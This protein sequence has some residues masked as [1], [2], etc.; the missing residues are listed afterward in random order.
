MIDFK[1]SI[2][3]SAE[4]VGSGYDLVLDDRNCECEEG[5]LA[6]QQY[7]RADLVPQ[8]QPIETMPANKLVFVL[9][10]SK[11]NTFTTML[12]LDGSTKNMGGAT[13]WMPIPKVPE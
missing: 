11:I 1:K 8:W 13:H 9:I 7:I 4:D 2:W 5:I 3:L 6:T 10:K 12:R